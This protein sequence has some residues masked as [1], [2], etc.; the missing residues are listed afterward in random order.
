MN[1]IIYYFSGTG[2]SLQ[3]AKD[4]SYELGETTFKVI[5]ADTQP[6]PADETV[7]SIGLVF[8]V[9]AWGAPKIV[10]EFIKRI[11]AKKNTYF[12]AIATCGGSPGKTL[13]E[14]QKILAANGFNLSAGFWLRQPSNYI[15]WGGAEAENKQHQYISQ[16]K[17][18]IKHIAEIIKKKEK[19]KPE[20]NGFLMNFFGSAI[21]RLFRK[22]CWRQA[23]NFWVTENCNQCRICVRICPTSNIQIN[24]KII[25]WGDKCEQCLACLQWCP[26]EAIQYKQKTLIRKRYHHPEIQTTEMLLRK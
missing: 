15:I 18:R 14:V 4:L 20:T 9:Y 22:N 13:L 6:Y 17:E 1:T 26:N 8:P 19:N 7:D 5:C 23:K 24:D 16:G 2:N 12:F 25:S 21:N 3:V 11:Q 10:T